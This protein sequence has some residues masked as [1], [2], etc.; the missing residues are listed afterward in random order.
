M[1]Q[2]HYAI[3]IAVPLSMLCL[4][5]LLVSVVLAMLYLKKK[6]I[7]K[8]IQAKN[9][10]IYEKELDTFPHHTVLHKD[11]PV[12]TLPLD[13]WEF[14]RERLQILGNRLLGTYLFITELTIS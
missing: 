6:R 9:I 7:N 3:Y 12:Q 2:G 8:R 4:I 13:L 14:P 1:Y 5:L 10:L 11:I